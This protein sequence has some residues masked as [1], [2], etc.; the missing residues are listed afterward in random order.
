MAKLKPEE[1]EAQGVRVGGKAEL[2]PH[3]LGLV[4]FTP[5]HFLCRDEEEMCVI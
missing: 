5:C 2:G 4:L 1:L 3:G